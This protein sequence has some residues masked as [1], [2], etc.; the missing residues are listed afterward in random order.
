MK[1]RLSMQGASLNVEV[2][3]KKAMGIY[4]G[5]AERLLL[6]T[7]ASEPQTE[8][9]KAEKPPAKIVREDVNMKDEPEERSPFSP[10][11][12]V[13]E[14]AQH[15]FQN[16]MSGLANSLSENEPEQYRGFLLIRCEHCGKIRAYCSNYPVTYHKCE[17]GH[18]TD[19]HDLK[20]LY[21]NCECGQRSY[22]RT[23]IEDPMIDMNCI[24]CG[25]P[26][27]VEWNAKK[28]CYGTIKERLSVLWTMIIAMNAW[29]TAITIMRTRRSIWY[30]DV[31]VAR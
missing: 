12:R 28:K 25:A 1:I 22:Y 21:A 7:G 14:E 8:K 9:E 13:A 3:D 20:P 17:C 2:S 19:L 16:A 15:N 10:L 24:S 11:I 27:A 18:K 23:N 29:D 31:R 5:L 30:V 26:V 4:R 6:Q